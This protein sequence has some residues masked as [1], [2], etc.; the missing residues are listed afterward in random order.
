MLA[1]FFLDALRPVPQRGNPERADAER[2]HEQDILFQ[3]VLSLACEAGLRPHDVVIILQ[4]AVTRAHTRD[5][6]ECEREGRETQRC[7]HDGHEE[8]L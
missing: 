5:S 7:R 4:G 8:L 2:R 3:M 6:R 1:F